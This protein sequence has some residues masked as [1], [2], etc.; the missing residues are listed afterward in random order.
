MKIPNYR[1]VLVKDGAAEY[2]VDNPAAAANVLRDVI[3]ADRTQEVVAVVAV[4]VKMK[5]MGASIINIGT[6]TDSPADVPSI[7][8]FVL[9]TG[10]PS[11]IV[12]H[13]HPSGDPKPSRRDRDFTV[14]LIA[15]AR[16][17]GLTLEDHLVVV[18]DDSYSMKLQETDLWRKSFS[19]TASGSA[20]TPN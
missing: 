3:G 9:L 8:R 11:F 5:P 6:A 13:N 15:A 17:V 1:A 19:F 14:T 16:L 18:D 2:R 7:L 12:G 4:N 20:L 10:A